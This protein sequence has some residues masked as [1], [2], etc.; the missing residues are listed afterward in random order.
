MKNFFI[1]L[2]KIILLSLIFIWIFA[3][4]CATVIDYPNISFWSNIE[5][6]FLLFLLILSWY[7]AN[8]LK[9]GANTKIIEYFFVLAPIIL[10]FLYYFIFIKKQI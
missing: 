8:K 6:L 5:F 9:K 1:I 3:G 7:L 2:Y 4:L 10:A